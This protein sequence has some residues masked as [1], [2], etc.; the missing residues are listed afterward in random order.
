MYVK[1]PY[2]MGW[3]S[4]WKQALLKAA[5]DHPESL[6]IEF[7]AAVPPGRNQEFLVRDTAAARPPEIS[8][9][10]YPET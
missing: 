2:S 7:I 4:A 10:K 6:V 9:C 1:T 5:S 8:S 3:W